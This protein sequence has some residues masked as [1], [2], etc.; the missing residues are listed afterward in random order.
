MSNKYLSD[1]HLGHA[2]ILEMSQRGERFVDVE[3]MNILYAS[4]IC[5]AH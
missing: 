5:P 3:E 1:L 4:G 2:R